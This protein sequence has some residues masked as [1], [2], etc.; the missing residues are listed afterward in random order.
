MKRMVVDNSV[1]MAWAFEDETDEYC[2]LVLDSFS[3]ATAL[4]P[5]LWPTEVAN[6]LCVAQRRKRITH[7]DALRFLQLL[8]QLPITIANLPDSANMQ[9]LYLLATDYALS[10][11]DAS[12]LQLALSEGLPLATRDTALCRAVKK[13]GGRIFK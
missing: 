7:S 4:V 9:N 12:Y 3:H 11:Y 10:A 1:V 5:C 2:E 13:V 8:A 6:V